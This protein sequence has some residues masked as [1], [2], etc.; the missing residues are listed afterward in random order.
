[1]RQEKL[2][3]LNILDPERH[4]KRILEQLQKDLRLSELPVQI[5]CF[6]NSNIQ[7]YNPVWAFVV[8]KKLKQFQDLGHNIILVIGDFTAMIGDPTGRNKPDHK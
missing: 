7:G 2:K 4:S 3:T 6:D 8:F 1:M 5:E